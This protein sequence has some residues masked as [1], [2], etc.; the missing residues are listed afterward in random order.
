MPASLYTAD[1]NANSGGL[2]DHRAMQLALELTMLAGLN[3]D[4]DTNTNGLSTAAQTFEDSA[5]RKRSANMTECVP[6]PS[7]EHVAEIVGRQG[8]KIKALRAKTNTYIKTPVRG[9]EPVFVV[10]GRKEDV[11]AAKRE[12]LSAADHFSQIRA[13]RRNNSASGVSGTSS[14]LTPGPPSPNTPGQVTIQVRVPY[15]VVG[16]VVGPKG[17]TIKR[18]QQQTHT[19]IVTP[20]RDKEPVFEVTGLPENVE[21]ARQEIES[22]IA[23]RT[24]GIIESHHAQDENDFHTNGVDSGFHELGSDIGSVYSKT[25]SSTSAFSTYTSSALN[26]NLLSRR[27]QEPTIFN[28]PPVT[29]TTSKLTDTYNPLTNGFNAFNSFNIYDNDEGISSPSFDPVPSP[30]GLWPE[31]ND[32]TAPGRGTSLVSVFT[33][34]GNNPTSTNTTSCSSVTNVLPLRRSS[35]GG[36]NTTPRLSPTLESASAMANGSGTGSLTATTLGGSSN[37]LD[38]HPMLRRIRSDPLTG[39]LAG[40]STSFGPLPTCTNNYATT[41]TTVTTITSSCPDSPPGGGG[42]GSRPRRHCLVCSESEV[43]AA[44]VPCGHNLFCMECA[45]LIVEKPAVE[46]LCPVCQQIPTQ[47]IRIF[48]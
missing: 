10:T 20:S 14:N 43:V 41:S 35:L 34:T 7:S 47:A 38:H 30:A 33:S 40:V 44:L 29:S 18:I 23:M 5:P 26:G 21:K 1:M 4:E 11:A 37:S 39:S 31:L 13:S 42:V 12:I 2:E 27:N 36:N 32:T 8:C 22:H 28:F 15:R 25:A 6:V 19:Y 16:L 46:R 3:A 48:S 17:A 9:E 24:G 45:N